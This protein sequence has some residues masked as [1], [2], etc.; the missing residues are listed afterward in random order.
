MIIHNTL[1]TTVR[2]GHDQ[3]N[4]KVPQF[5]SILNNTVLFIRYVMFGNVS[6]HN[7][8]HFMENRL[9]CLDGTLELGFRHLQNCLDS[10]HNVLLDT[11]N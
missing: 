2:L 10:H 11:K 6:L 4:C 5:R 1:I 9:G 8:K 3:E 7:R